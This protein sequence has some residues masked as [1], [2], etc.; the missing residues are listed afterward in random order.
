MLSVFFFLSLCV[1]VFYIFIKSMAF[2]QIDIVIFKN[3]FNAHSNKRINHAFV[4]LHAAYRTRMKLNHPTSIACI[5]A[6]S[7]HHTRTIAAFMHICDEHSNHKQLKKKRAEK[8]IKFIEEIATTATILKI[9]MN[10]ELAHGKGMRAHKTGNGSC[11]EHT[12]ALNDHID[13]DSTVGFNAD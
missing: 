9:E 2:Y 10:K 6:C 3:A 5:V 11:G 8:K 12:I 13:A 1:F 7:K 4:V